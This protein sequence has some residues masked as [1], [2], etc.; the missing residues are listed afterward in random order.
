MKIT[1]YNLWTTYTPTYRK[2]NASLEKITVLTVIAKKLMCSRGQ[3]LRKNKKNSLN[4]SFLV[5]A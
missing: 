2:L 5:V 3:I 4:L 1:A